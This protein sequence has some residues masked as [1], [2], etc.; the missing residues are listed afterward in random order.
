LAVDDDSRYHSSHNIRMLRLTAIVVSRVQTDLTGVPCARL[1]A[2][3]L[4]AL[5]GAIR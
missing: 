4:D 5:K 3:L 2:M 1:Y